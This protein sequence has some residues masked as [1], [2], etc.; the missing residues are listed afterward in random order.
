MWSGASVVHCGSI[1]IC[2]GAE[3]SPSLMAEHRWGGDLR[4]PPFAN[5]VHW[6]A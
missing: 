3:G 2:M 6:L 4:S 5:C 1:D